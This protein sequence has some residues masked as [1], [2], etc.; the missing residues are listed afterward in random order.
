MALFSEN[1]FNEIADFTQLERTITGSIR[2]AAKNPATLYLFFQRYTYFNAYASSAISGLATSIGLSRYLFKNSELL[3]IE[4][5]DRGMEIAAQVMSAAADEGIKGMPVHRALA[6]LTLKTV[7]N[8]AELSVEERNEFAK[9][10]TWLD[11]IIKELIINY[12]GTPGDIASLVRAMG[13][14]FASELMGDRESALVDMVIRH[15]NKGIGFDRYLKEKST[16]VQIDG[17]RYSP[18]SWIIIHSKF[19][20]PGV[21]AQHCEYALNALN[22]TVRYCSESEQQIL[23]WA[24]EGFA[25]F[26]ELQQR[27]FME[28]HRECLE[29]LHGVKKSNLVPIS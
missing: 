20:S 4:E 19:D 18:W 15:E 2:L 10:P 26:V 13:F 12:Q 1:T 5:A 28:S 29:I 9:I 25:K 22:M 21:E 14:N 8:Y 6:Q 27:L 11:E 23:T 3:V 16:P 24:K 7:G 17:H